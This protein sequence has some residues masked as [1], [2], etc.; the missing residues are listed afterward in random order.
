MNLNSRSKSS[1][2]TGMSAAGLFL[3]NLV[4]EYKYHLFPPGNGS[5]LYNINQIMFFIALIGYLIVL[6]GLQKTKATGGGGFGNFSIWLFITAI[7]ILIVAQILRLA[8]NIVDIILFPIGGIFQ[9]IG[10]LLTGIAVIT[11]KKWSGWQ[12]FAPMLQGSYYLFL[13][14]QVGAFNQQLTLVTEGIWQ[15]T[16]FITSLALYTS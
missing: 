4:I 9:L 14:V 10:G 1:G 11:A 13:F 6:F 15:V 12:R 16:W 3:I 2:F 8:T 7:S 5:F